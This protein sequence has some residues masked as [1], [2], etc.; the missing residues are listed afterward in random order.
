MLNWH[1]TAKQLKYFCDYV[2]LGKTK[3][4]FQKAQLQCAVIHYLNM[5]APH[6]A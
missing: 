1:I 6:T 2:G 5:E 3:G 4:V